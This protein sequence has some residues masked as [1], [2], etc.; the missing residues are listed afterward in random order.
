MKILYLLGR[1]LFFAYSVIGIKPFIAYYIPG[2]NIFIIAFI[3][4]T[5]AAFNEIY[6]EKRAVDRYKE[7]E[8]I[9]LEAIRTKIEKD[10]ICYTAHQNHQ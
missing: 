2:T 6:L 7:R 4:G 10:N 3:V 9:M 1:I 8:V 5:L